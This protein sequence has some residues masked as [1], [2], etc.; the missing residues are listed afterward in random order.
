MRCFTLF[1][2]IW[3]VVL[4]V[5]A[6]SSG[7][8]AQ[9]RSTSLI[10]TIVGGN[11]T[12]LFG[13]DF[14][15]ASV[16]DMAADTR[17]NLYF[18]QPSLK[19]VFRINPE[20][21][22]TVYAGNGVRGEH[23][24]GAL[25]VESPLLITPNLAVDA[26]GNLFIEDWYSLLRVDASTGVI[27]TVLNI[28]N[29]QTGGES[30]IVGVGGM[31]VG[32]DG[33]LYIADV[34]NRIKR[35]AFG[36]GVITIVAGNGADGAVQVGVPATMSPLHSPKQVIVGKDGTV[37]FS[38][39]DQVFR[40]RPENNKLE[41]VNL[42]V[43]KEPPLGDRRFLEDIAL[44]AS[45][46][47]F[48]AQ[49]YAFRVLRV[50]TKSGKVSVY[51]GTGTRQ[52]N[53]DGIKAVHANLDLP[54]HIVLDAS[55]ELVIA[56]HYRIRRVEASTN[57][58]RTVIGNGLPMTSAVRVPAAQ[59][60]LLEPAYVAPA[61]D[62]SL[63]ITSSFSRRLLVVDPQGSV[64][65]AAGGGSPWQTDAPGLADKVSL[66]Y[67]QGIWLD[68]NGE[69]YFA[70][71]DNKII[72]RLIPESGTVANFAVMP[73]DS[74]SSTSY[75]MYAG[76]LVA[77]TDHFYLSDPLDHR[78]WRVSRRDGNAESWAGTGSRDPYAK[79]GDGDDAQFARLISP[80]GLALDPSGALFIADGGY[81]SYTPGRIVR[82]TRD[83]K[84]STVLS[85]LDQ[86]N[87]LAFESPDV[88]C[89]A[90]TGANQVKCLNLVDH[91]IRVLVGTG[92][93]GSAGDGGSAECAQLNRPSGISFDQQ[94]NLYIADT[95][96][97]RIRRVRVTKGREATGC[98]AATGARPAH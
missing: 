83:R 19:Q 29:R 72:R 82:V 4:V 84:I 14:S 88:L 10:E 40:I 39:A 3:I 53:G 70:D 38:T 5:L 57:L 46:N 56:E 54:E 75:L 9:Q 59:A 2:A 69:V 76:A 18:T 96:N 28:G 8:V 25:A 27:S 32:P 7:L 16:G 78:V 24:E 34:D 66:D 41:A 68:S 11:R 92:V 61:P 20:G 81:R 94:G 30:S 51:A 93:A 79:S 85:N 31:S 90:E 74:S 42:Q 17:G 86:P 43:D 49:P 26:A 48:V 80:S 21:K 44:D 52:F 65:T 63:Y 33:D 6:D 64:V 35:Y 77:D 22:V 73:R 1:R 89:F 50:E 15:I 55:G 58:I 36:S 45:D 37:Y 97:Q 23:R 98:N 87:G 71:H 47:L 13:E 62:G 12:N 60:A 91:S 67:P 95:G